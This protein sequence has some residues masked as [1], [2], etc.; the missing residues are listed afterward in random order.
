[1]ISARVVVRSIVAVLAVPR[2]PEMPA[3]YVHGYAVDP[4]EDV[5][6][7]VAAGWSWA[8]GGVVSTPRDADRFVRGY[9]T[10]ATTDP[11]TKA[12][13][14]E[15]VRRGHSEPPGPGEN[16]AGLGIFRYRSS[17]GTV[18]GHTGNTPGYTQF[19]AASADGTRSTTVS[20]NA[21]ITPTT[22]PARFGLLRRIFGLAVCA[23]M[24]NP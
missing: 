23:A 9:V 17:C 13:Q 16:A 22:D 18:Y 3:P 12:E 21:Q 15:F 7:L 5:S 6:E 24:A 1:M 10:G 8:S 11:A 2:G 20:V 19:V 4:L 14:F